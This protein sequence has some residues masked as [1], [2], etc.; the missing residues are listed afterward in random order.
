MKFLM[1]IFGASSARRNG[2]HLAMAKTMF[3]RCFPQDP[4]P[5]IVRLVAQLKGV[6]RDINRRII[7]IVNLQVVVVLRQLEQPLRRGS[8]GVGRGHDLDLRTCL[9]GLGGEVA[10]EIAD[11]THLSQPVSQRRGDHADC[12]GREP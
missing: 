7:P 9:C 12:A 8:Q 1:E 6:Q 11:A 4:F 2:E 5:S 3:R 10:D